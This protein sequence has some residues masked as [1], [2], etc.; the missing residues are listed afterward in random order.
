M[1][2]LTTADR[3]RHELEKSIVEEIERLKENIALGFL[4]DYAQYKNLA[5]KI[6]GLRSSLDLISEAVRRC[7]EEGV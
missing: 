1:A 5:G 2:I 6:S 3:F 7:N 4:D